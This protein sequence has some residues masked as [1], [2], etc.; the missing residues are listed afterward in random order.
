MEEQL[1]FFA[2]MC[3]TL[4]DKWEDGIQNDCGVYTQNVHKYQEG[5]HKQGYELE[6]KLAKVKDEILFDSSLAFKD[7]GSYSPLSDY[8]I[9]FP[10]TLSAENLCSTL[11]QLV[12]Y[13]IDS[14]AN[15]NGYQNSRP[16]LKEALGRLIIKIKEDLCK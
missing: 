16:K 2:Q 3:G 12:E 1:D 13:R 8:S 7:Y 9:H 10:R 4:T 6:I 14:N 15:L 5:S 11:R